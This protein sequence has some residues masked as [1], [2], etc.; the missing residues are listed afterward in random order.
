MTKLAFEQLFICQRPA[1]A[2]AGGVW[3]VVTPAMTAWPVP[4]PMP[5][6]MGTV[7]GFVSREVRAQ[8]KRH[9]QY[10]ASNYTVGLPGCV[11]LP[12]GRHAS[13]ATKFMQLMTVSSIIYA[14]HNVVFG[15]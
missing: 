15:R 9:G 8:Q 5:S 2:T 7:A 3:P 4:V 6:P 1:C 10:I 11:R 13:F 12:P 14:T